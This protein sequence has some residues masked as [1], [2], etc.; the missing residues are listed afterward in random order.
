MAMRLGI[1]TKKQAYQAFGLIALILCAGGYEIYHIFFADSPHPV[2]SPQPANSAV[3]KP[4]K[5]QDAH[6]TATNPA[7]AGQQAQKISTIDMDPALHLEV[8]ARS[9]AIEYQGT[10]RNIFS[11]ESAPAPIEKLVAG[12]RPNLPGQPGVS[13]QQPVV[14]R[15]TAPAIDL[16]YFGYTQARDK[17][18]QAF[19][20]RGDDIFVAR[21]GEIVDHRYK[22]DVIQPNSVQ[23]TDLGYN[24]TQTL[25]LQ[26]N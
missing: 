21:N 26:G 9:E 25:Q 12:P 5:S 10:G 15:P 8:L 1:E 11:A 7:D 4:S 24:N 20:I 22:V 23:V 13:I 14:A 6:S 16:K 18:L 3:T 19:F 17:S 2:V